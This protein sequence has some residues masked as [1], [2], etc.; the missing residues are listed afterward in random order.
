MVTGK[1][2][3][4]DTGDRLY[5]PRGT[6]YASMTHQGASYFWC[7]KPAADD[8]QGSG[9][10]PSGDSNVQQTTQEETPWWNK[11][12]NTN[13]KSINCSVTYFKWILNQPEINYKFVLFFIEIGPNGFIKLFTKSN[14]RWSGGPDGGSR[15]YAD[16][17][18]EYY[19]NNYRRCWQKGTK[20]WTNKICD[21]FC[22]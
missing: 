4:A 13:L 15:W 22:F 11:K 14:R 6:V 9:Q 3:N 21:I 5:L 16:T 19:L 1:K 2:Y 8:G 20:N 18:G 10:W 17:P 7:S 12:C